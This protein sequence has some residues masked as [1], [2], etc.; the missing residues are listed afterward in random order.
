MRK[1]E[2]YLGNGKIYVW[3]ETF[4]IAKALLKLQSLG[5]RIKEK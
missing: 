5:C 1:V 3:R 4:A 2:D